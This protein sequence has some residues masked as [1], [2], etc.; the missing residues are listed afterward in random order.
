VELQVTEL[1][2]KPRT[3]MD[4]P[5]IKMPGTRNAA[6][7]SQ[8]AFDPR[9]GPSMDSSSSSMMIPGVGGGGGG[10]VGGGGGGGGNGG[11]GLGAGGG[12]V[13]GSQTGFVGKSAEEVYE[14][15]Y[16]VQT[17]EMLEEWD[18]VKTNRWG[19]RQK[20]VIGVGKDT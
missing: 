20:R 8:P 3:Y 2:L 15:M 12:A 13:N 11:G 7:A 16:V 18:I 19:K 14:L 5:R 9:M 17:A 10:G 6:S 4:Q 1:E